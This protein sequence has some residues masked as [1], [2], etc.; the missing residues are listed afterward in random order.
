MKGLMKDQSRKKEN[1]HITL[2]TI[3]NKKGHV[4]KLF[5]TLSWPVT[6]KELKGYVDDR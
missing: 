2:T 3:A 6:K 5:Q 1:T 4:F